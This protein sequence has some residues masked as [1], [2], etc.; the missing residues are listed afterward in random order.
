MTEQNTEQSSD[1][2]LQQIKEKLSQ[3]KHNHSTLKINRVPD[4][5]INQLQDL[6]YDKFAGDYG[7]TLAYLLELDS[8]AANVS[9]RQIELAERVTKLE[10]LLEQ[11]QAQEENQSNNTETSKINTIR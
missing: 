3:K 4:R 9:D 2:T 6:A 7:A 1:D 8:V 5:A 11:I 10:N